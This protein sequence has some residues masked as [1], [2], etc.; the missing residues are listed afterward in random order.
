MEN[1]WKDGS[2]VGLGDAIENLGIPVISWLVVVSNVRVRVVVI[3]LNLFV[4]RRA[5]ANTLFGLVK[6]SYQFG[7]CGTIFFGEVKYLQRWV[8][9]INC[10]SIWAMVIK[11]QPL[12][13]E[14]GK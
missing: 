14:L 12:D 11:C 7:F 3:N 13:M 1:K 4:F 8:T 5:R 9:K 6:F 2:M 10:V